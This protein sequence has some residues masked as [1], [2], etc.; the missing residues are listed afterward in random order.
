MKDQAMT[1]PID[2]SKLPLSPWAPIAAII[3]LV[4]MAA[5]G[6]A[7]GGTLGIL[8]LICAAAARHDIKR[9]I[10]GGRNWATAAIWFGA[11]ALA[12]SFIYHMA[13]V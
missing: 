9:G 7:F 3:G 11:A 10:R 8:A 12:G 1:K 13:T 2:D 4:G 5:I 6:R